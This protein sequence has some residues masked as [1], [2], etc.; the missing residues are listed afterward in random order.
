M[1]QLLTKILASWLS[2]L[3]LQY[4]SCRPWWVALPKAHFNLQWNACGWSLKSN[5]YNSNFKMTNILLEGLQ[6]V[7]ISVFQQL[8]VRYSKFKSSQQDK[9][10]SICLWTTLKYPLR[11]EWSEI[12]HFSPTVCRGAWEF[13]RERSKFLKKSDI[14]VKSTKKSFMNLF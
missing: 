13:G 2:P 4:A 11:R 14:V 7:G 10:S 6:A 9:I 8:R 12:L 5:H 3:T 1:F